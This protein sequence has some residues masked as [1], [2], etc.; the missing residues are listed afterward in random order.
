MW[1]LLALVL[2]GLVPSWRFFGQVG[3]SPR[4]DIWRDGAWVPALD[5]PDQVRLGARLRRLAWNP[6]WNRHLFTVTLAERILTAAPAPDPVDI[7][8]MQESLGG[9]AVR[10]RISVLHR[11]GAGLTRTPVYDSGSGAVDG[12][13]A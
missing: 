1:R 13:A 4:V 2:P 3:A 6:A 9:E 11:A 8:L 10:F 12:P 7:A 5:W